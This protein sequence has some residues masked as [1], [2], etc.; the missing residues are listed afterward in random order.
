[1]SHLSEFDE[2][3]LSDVS[4]LKERTENIKESTDEIKKMVREING[5]LTN[6][7][8]SL[9]RSRSWLHG[10]STGISAIVAFIVSIIFRLF[11][12]G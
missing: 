1:M 6:R 7:I 4:M 3:I 12:N 5:T 10:M 9:E 11:N 2:R 8:A